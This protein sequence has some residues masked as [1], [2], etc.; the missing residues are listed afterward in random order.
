MFVSRGL[1]ARIS[2]LKPIFSALA[3]DSSVVPVVEHCFLNFLKY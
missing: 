1:I 2:V 3:I